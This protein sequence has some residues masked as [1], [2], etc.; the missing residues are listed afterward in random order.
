MSSPLCVDIAIVN[1]FSAADVGRCLERLGAWTHGTVWLIDNSS[2][3]SEMGQLRRLAAERPW[4]RLIDAA[5]NLG[6]GRACNLAFQQSSAPFFLL[7]NPDAQA[8]PADLLMLAQSLHDNPRLGA[9]SP[10]IF[11][12]EARTFVLPAAS[13]QT[14]FTALAQSLASRSHALALW[15]AQRCLREQRQRMVLSAP[16]EVAFLA[17]AVM[18]LRRHA[19]LAA[20]GLFDPDYFMFFED[21]DLSLRLRRRGWRLA[22]VPRATA[23]HEYRH[24]PFKAALMSDSRERFYRKRYPWFHRISGA[25]SRVD[26]LAKPV[27]VQRWF[28]E[29]ARPCGTSEDFNTQAGHAGVIAFSPSM[30]M[31]PAIFRPQGEG[32]RPFS[33]AEWE[34]LEPAGY[35]ALVEDRSAT[36]RW[37][38]FRRTG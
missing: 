28:E 30:L 27:P 37:I 4:V 24:K 29:L 18:M 17:G 25:L 15:I 26:G 12:N 23:V 6:F 10:M 14:P 9:V 20:G 38:H 1:Y 5:G 7:L 2:D 34:L 3:A 19:V 13:A 32:A 35:V 11:W 21:S 16:F 33:A 8:A 22:M 31:M 36:Q